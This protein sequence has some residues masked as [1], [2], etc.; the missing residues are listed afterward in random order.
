LVQH[1][2]SVHKISP[3]D[4]NT[5]R[6][7]VVDERTNFYDPENKQDT[8]R[9]LCS[10]LTCYDLNFMLMAEEHKGGIYMWVSLASGAGLVNGRTFQCNIS[11]VPENSFSSQGLTWE[12]EVYPL[13][14]RFEHIV[15]MEDTLL[16]KKMALSKKYIYIKDEL[17]VWNV[18]FWIKEALFQGISLTMGVDGSSRNTSPRSAGKGQGT[19][20]GTSSQYTGT[21]RFICS[22]SAPSA[23]P[24]NLYESPKSE[25]LIL[26]S[27]YEE[28]SPDPG[29]KEI[30][31]PKLTRKTPPVEVD[32]YQ[33]MPLSVKSAH[34]Q[35]KPRPLPRTR[36]RLC[37]ESDESESED[38]E[39]DA[40]IVVLDDDEV[41]TS[42]SEIMD[43]SPQPDSPR[44]P[45][46]AFLPTAGQCR[47]TAT[48]QNTNAPAPST[49]QGPRRKV[50]ARRELAMQQLQELISRVDFSRGSKQ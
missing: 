15:S 48:E 9:W 7:Q 19:G 16:I 36:Q 5:L 42:E 24:T 14:E 2:V 21:D 8:N 50:E 18:D 27:D 12:G 31:T 17:L 45:E 41:T 20:T 4:S 43:E 3:L 37:V 11:L 10:L 46:N 47:G 6:V 30:S 26:D 44:P 29:Q 35:P 34:A 40:T 25:P 32:M 39:S 38:P 23:P 13:E 22:G 33:D 49:F 1:L 28:S